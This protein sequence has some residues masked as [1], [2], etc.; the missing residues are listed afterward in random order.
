MRSR[1]S[2]A[3]ASISLTVPP[4]KVVAATAT[5]ALAQTTTPQAKHAMASA[6]HTSSKAASAAVSSL[7]TKS[8]LTIYGMTLKI[9]REEGGV[10]GLYR[11]MITT[12][13]GVAPYVG[14]NFATYEALRSVITPPGKTNIARKLTC[15]AL[16]GQFCLFS[17]TPCAHS[18]P[19]VQSHK[20]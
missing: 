13:V 6:Y 15:G 20:R 3:T 10:R 4:A 14:I 17:N 18:S 7:Y 19:Q 5:P 9:M 12:A 11:G 16:A 8:E 2:I 1:L